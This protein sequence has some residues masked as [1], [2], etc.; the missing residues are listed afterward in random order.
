VGPARTLT[1]YEGKAVS[2]AESASSAVQTVRLAAQT[3]SDGHAF[4]PYLSI[5]ISEQ[6]DALAGVEGTFGSIQPP[7]EEADDLRDELDA[8]LS[9]ALD[10]VSAVRIAVRRGDLD[11]LARVAEPLGGDAAS[12]SAFAE[13]HRS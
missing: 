5:T 2:T 13:D 10:H 4:G 12:L 8:L 11:G 1:T 6:E 9:R 3:G 7:G